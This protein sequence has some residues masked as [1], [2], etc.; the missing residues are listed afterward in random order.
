MNLEARLG[1]PVSPRLGWGRCLDGLSVHRQ[2]L[3]YVDSA[4]PLPLLGLHQSF[5]YSLFDFAG[6]YRAS[7]CWPQ[8]LC[9]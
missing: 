2:G 8:G 9:G 5:V 1:R 7:V 6:V 4:C 3:L